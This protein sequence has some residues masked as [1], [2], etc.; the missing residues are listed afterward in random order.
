VLDMVTTG[1]ELREEVDVEE[2][3]P[4][5]DESSREGSRLNDASAREPLPDDH[6]LLALCPTSLLCTETDSYSSA[7]YLPP[8]RDPFFDSAQG[9]PAEKEEIF[10]RACMGS[11]SYVRPRYLRDSQPSTFSCQL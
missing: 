6:L 2:E 11:S 10:G 3:E 5:I 8:L 1:W 7:T 9:G 4:E